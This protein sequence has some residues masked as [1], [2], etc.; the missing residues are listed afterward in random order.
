MRRKVY[1]SDVVHVSGDKLAEDSDCLVIDD[2]YLNHIEDAN[3][4]RI[5]NFCITGIELLLNKIAVD[6]SPKLPV[7]FGSRFGPLKSVHDF[8][9]ICVI[10]G[11]LHA[12]PGRFPNAV[13]NSPTCR[14]SIAHKINGPIYNVANGIFSS[15]DALG[16]AYMALCNYAFD[17][18]IVCG[19]D[20][21]SPL[22]RKMSD[23]DF[24]YV[25]SFGALLLT[26]N[27]QCGHEII[28]YDKY[29]YSDRSGESMTKIL[30]K[31]CPE[32]TQLMYIANP[33]SHKIAAEFNS[34]CYDRLELFFSDVD[35]GGVGGFSA[36][37]AQINARV[38]HSAVTYIVNICDDYIS[39]L[40]VK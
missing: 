26:T 29:R 17:S 7:F 30:Q 4:D 31:C 11:A 5:S 23:R 6:V 27:R 25:E 2:I 36:V 10:N 12:K 20:E 39:A 1:I 18:A 32:K 16:L 9:K 21:Y 3:V 14:A 28:G 19:A 34:A 35:Y 24:T 15:L 13:L 37:N 22:Q 8:D 40:T 38:Y 33:L